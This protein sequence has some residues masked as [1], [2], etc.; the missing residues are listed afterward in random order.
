MQSIAPLLTDLSNMGGNTHTSLVQQQTDLLAETGTNGPALLQHGL[1]A[2][3]QETRPTTGKVTS[4]TS[5][6]CSSAGQD[7]T[8]R[9]H[10]CLLFPLFPLSLFQPPGG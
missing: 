1:K 9:Q 5:L 7:K 3:H 6:Q 8:T 4:M 2:R 10:F